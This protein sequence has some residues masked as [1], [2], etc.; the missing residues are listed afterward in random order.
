MPPDTSKRGQ[1]GQ[2]IAHHRSE[3][4][5]SQHNLAT[6]TRSS[7]KEV[8]R[9]EKGDLVPTT[10]EW[11]RLRATFHQLNAAHFRDLYA[12]A[13]AEQLG[14]EE[15][16]TSVDDKRDGGGGIWTL[17][18]AS[19]WTRCRTCARSPSMSTTTGRCP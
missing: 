13:A 5:M 2:V 16:R 12:A 18:S 14:I 17:P 10:T 3:L 8:D 19:S 4:S 9:W 15:A 11:Q 1:L 6:K 7:I